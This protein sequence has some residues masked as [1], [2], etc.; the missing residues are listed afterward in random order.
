MHLNWK[1]QYCQN[2][3]T[4]RGNLQI[5]CNYTDPTPR[6]MKMKNKQTNKKPKWD[7]VVVQSL[8]YIQLFATQ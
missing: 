8:S 6:V 2:V 7:F 4:A 1:N 3:Y 5:Q